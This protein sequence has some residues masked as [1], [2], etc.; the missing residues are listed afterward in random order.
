MA[1]VE[2]IAL[3]RPVTVTGGYDRSC[4]ERR[5]GR[6][7]RGRGD[8]RL[9][10]RA[11][12]RVRGRRGHRARR[13]R[14]WGRG[15]AGVGWRAR[16][17]HRGT[18]GRR[19]ARSHGPEPGALRRVDRM[20]CAPSR[21]S[22]SSIAAPAASRWRWTP[23]RRRR[24]LSVP[25][26]GSRN[27]WPGSSGWTARAAAGPSP[28]SRTRRSERLR[29]RTHGYVAATGPDRGAGAGAIARGA[30]G[31]QRLSRQ[32]R[33]SSVEPISMRSG[34]AVD[35]HSWR[36][37]RVVVAA[38]SWTS[39]LEGLSDAVAHD[40][41]PVRGQLLR[42]SW[43]AHAAPAGHLG[44][45]LLPGAMGGWH[46]ARRRDVED[47]G[48]EERNTVG[49]RADAAGGRAKTAAGDGRGDVSRSALGPASRD[50]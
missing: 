44:A 1:C 7:R 13:P 26:R 19:A 25:R 3:P 34:H 10:R 45:R 20:R 4:R 17:V 40:V 46:G 18:R 37:K 14:R 22:T 33:S 2:A 27:A 8:H 35:G 36:A 6:R 43:R 9:R 15:D 49:G 47:A 11:R 24:L 42:V 21:A 30:S 38:G 12:A 28:R 5:R 29:C 32:P 16:A 41:R 48:F 39:Q 50:V 23:E 31:P